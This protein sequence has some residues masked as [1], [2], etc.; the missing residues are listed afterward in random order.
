MTRFNA[1]LAV[2]LCA[3]ASAFGVPSRVTAARVSRRAVCMS[4]DKAVVRQYFNTEGFDRWN[5]IYSEDGEVNSVQKDI[6]N[7]HQQTVDKILAWIDADANIAEKTVCDAGCGVGS[8]ALPLAAR[9]AR[10]TASDISDAM[11]A[12][13]ARRAD[14]APGLAIKP[15]FFASDLSALSGKYNTVTCVDVMIHYPTE[16]MAGM[17]AHLASLA[18]K[19]LIIS[20]A[21]K[22]WYYDLLKGFGGLFPGP[23]KTTRAYLHPE[24][25]VVAALAAAGFSTRRTEMTGTNFYFSRLLEAERD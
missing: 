11:V 17:V 23:S 6:R 10:V 21:P 15:E 1:V 4:N 16:E 22:T 24:E 25:D 7:G 19:R 2:A 18:E 13:A 3:R 8:L 12:E 20:F 5:R 14:L 9:G